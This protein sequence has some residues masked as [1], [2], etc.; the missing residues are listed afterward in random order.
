MT[1]LIVH[2]RRPTGWADTVRIHYWNTRPEDQRTQWPGAA[3][4][5]E[6]GGWF[7]HHF[8]GVEAASLVFAFY[9]E[10]VDAIEERPEA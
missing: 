6:G 2:F 8:A 3:M 7:V 10:R 5:A 4:L 1:D 9:P